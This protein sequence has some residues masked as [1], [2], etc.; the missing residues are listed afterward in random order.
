MLSCSE[1]VLSGDALRISLDISDTVRSHFEDYFTITESI[2]LQEN[3]SIHVTQIKKIIEYNEEYYVM[4]YSGNVNFLVFDKKGNFLRRIGAP[5]K[6]HHEYSHPRDFAIDRKNRKF[7]VLCEGS[8]LKAYTLFGEFIDDK[9]LSESVL[10]NIASVDGTI[11]CT[12]NHHTYRE[13]DDACLFY[14]FDSDYNLLRKH[15]QVLPEYMGMILIANPCLKEC[16]NCYSYLDFYTHKL[17]VLDRKGT[18]ENTYAFGKSNLMPYKYFRDY[19]AFT[20]VQFNY[21]F[22]TDN[23]MT[24]E[25]IVSVFKNRKQLCL[26]ISDYSGKVLLN[27]PIRGFI[28][29]FY[30]CDGSCII[31]ATTREYFEERDSQC[32]AE[33]GN[34]PFHY[35]LKC[36]IK[37]AY[38][39]R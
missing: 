4:D 9:V 28:P 19:S 8:L 15:T 13:G 27:K 33:G 2:G 35:I 38:Q 23:I 6:A 24:D 29:K 18:I 3:D 36:R 32:F 22:I 17:Y 10:E 25:S 26:N 34:I 16:S 12:T 7:L 1:T 30:S 14:L 37:P 11:L 31:T 39:S 21:D 20:E 5:G